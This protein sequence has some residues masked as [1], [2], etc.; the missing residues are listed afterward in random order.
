MTDVPVPDKM[1]DKV[2]DKAAYV[3]AQ[4]LRN[5]Y[6]GGALLVFV[7]L[8]FFISMTRMAAGLKH[9][10]AERA[11]FHVSAAAAAASK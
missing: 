9:D 2:S 3:K 10:K 4:K 5:L 8:V 6:I 7:V 11:Q 1:A